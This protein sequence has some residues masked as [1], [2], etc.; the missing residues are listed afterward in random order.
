MNLQRHDG[1][2][3]NPQT[4]RSNVETYAMMVD[5]RRDQSPDMKPSRCSEPL[6][7]HNWLDRVSCDSIEWILREL[8]WFP[9]PPARKTCNFNL[10]HLQQTFGIN[11]LCSSAK[12]CNQ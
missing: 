4:V 2:Y 8:L 10:P 6:V 12:A 7:I 9:L 11:R 3:N 1:D 5:Y